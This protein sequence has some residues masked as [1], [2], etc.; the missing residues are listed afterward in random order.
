MDE[1]ISNLKIRH[2]VEM[3]Q[4]SEKLSNRLSEQLSVSHQEISALN[5]TISTLREQNLAIQVLFKKK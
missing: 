2:A 5:Q 4:L 3:Q 1:Q